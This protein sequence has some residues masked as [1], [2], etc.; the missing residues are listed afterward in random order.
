MLKRVGICGWFDD[1]GRLYSFCE[2]GACARSLTIPAKVRFGTEP[3]VHTFL[4]ISI[5]IVV[6]FGL[7]YTCEGTWIWGDEKDLSKSV[8]TRQVVKT[9]QKVSVLDTS[10]NLSLS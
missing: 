1:P 3:W 5:L 6:S 10:A 8:Q 7:A 2:T 9:I 4:I